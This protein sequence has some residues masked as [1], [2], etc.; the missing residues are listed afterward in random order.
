[1]EY[2]FCCFLHH[3]LFCCHAFWDKFQKIKDCYK[4]CSRDFSQQTSPRSWCMLESEAMLLAIFNFLKRA[5]FN[6]VLQRLVL[7]CPLQN[8]QM[9][10]NVQ[11]FSSSC[12]HMSLEVAGNLLVENDVISFCTR[13]TSLFNSSK[14]SLCIRVFTVWH[15][16]QKMLSNGR[17]EAAE[18]QPRQ[19]DG[20][21]L[22]R[23]GACRRH[24][25]CSGLYC[26]GALCGLSA[27]WDDGSKCPSTTAS[28]TKCLIFSV[29]DDKRKIVLDN[30]NGKTWSRSGVLSVWRMAYDMNRIYSTV[31]VC[32]QRCQRCAKHMEHHVSPLHRGPSNLVF[33]NLMSRVYT[34]L[35]SSFI[36]NICC[37]SPKTLHV[38]SENHTLPNIQDQNQ[39]LMN[40]QVQA[41]KAK[42]F[43]EAF[44]IV[45]SRPGASKFYFASWTLG[46]LEGWG[47]V[48]GLQYF[49]A[50]GIGFLRGYVFFWGGHV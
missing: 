14:I 4:N 9:P 49:H 21:A 12:L 41:G 48:E 10:L 30:K 2:H 47:D 1:M 43:S 38:G 29:E 34:C 42:N 26:A 33:C 13:R 25:R 16:F 6:W 22:R 11:W 27:W 7:T 36:L 18:W 45:F 39:E 5:I 37:I 40:K 17:I 23:H 46:Q 44:D 15:I 31:M 32:W 50:K 19:C 20:T 8:L 35:Y 3:L 28:T 24:C